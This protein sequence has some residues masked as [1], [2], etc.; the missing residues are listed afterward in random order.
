MPIWDRQLRDLVMA[1]FEHAANL[2][3]QDGFARDTAEMH[4]DAT[5]SA[6]PASPRINLPWPGRCPACKPTLDDSIDTTS[7]MPAHRQH[8][9]AAQV[10]TANL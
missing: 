2:A 8:P 9:K 4:P 7:Q 5:P 1:V 10:P 6:I 3:E